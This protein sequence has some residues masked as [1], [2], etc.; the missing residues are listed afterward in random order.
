MIARLRSVSLALLAAASLVACERP[1]E[2]PQPVVPTVEIENDV[3]GFPAG[4]PQL[5]SVRLADVTPERE[6]FVRINGRVA[7]DE[8]RTV[9]LN[10]P[11]TG[12][13]LAIQAELGMKVQRGDS[14]LVI[15]S[16]E[17]GQSQTDARRAVTDLQMAERALARS[18]E[19]HQAGVIPTKELELAEADH[20]R[21]VAERDRTVALERLYGASRSAIDQQFRLRSPIDGVV[22]ER[23]VNVGQ[24][25]RPDASPDG[26]M[27]VVSD[28]SRLWIMLDVPEAL[29]KEIAVGETVRITVPALPGEVFSAQVQYVADAIDPQS[30]TVKAR[31]AVENPGRK[32]KSEMYVTADVDV[33][34]T[35]ALRVPATSVYLLED[36]QYAFVEV[37]PGRFAR[38]QLRAEQASL[39]TMRVLDGIK[40]GEKVVA[41]GALLLQQLLNQKATEP[42][43]SPARDEAR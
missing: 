36:Q 15:S 31:A 23:R 27:F 40:P 3:V 21:A 43:A 13:V 42:G 17:I 8:S 30:R 20:A 16:P 1:P 38:R 14:L 5:A 2:A 9:R 28:P 24:E 25:V 10:P 35:S 4:S 19:L 32:L 41:D 29:T 39:G 22:V 7:W 18:R 37:G 12:R 34:A 33:P 11:V 6:S 26:P